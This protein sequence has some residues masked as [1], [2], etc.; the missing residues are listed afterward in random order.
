MSGSAPIRFA[1]MSMGL[2]AVVRK[3]R[4]RSVYNEIRYRLS[5]IETAIHDVNVSTP[6]RTNQLRN[7]S[8]E[9]VGINGSV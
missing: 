1:T 2:T 3:G 4:L 9:I 5:S 7:E 8:G 6:S